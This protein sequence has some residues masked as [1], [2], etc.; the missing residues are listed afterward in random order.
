MRSTKVIHVVNCHAEGEVGDVIVG[1]V[2]PPPG[3]TLWEQSRFIASDQTLRNFVLNEPRG[4]V[5]RHVNLLVPAKDPRAQMG[6][7]IME[8]EDTPPMSG[9]N[10]IC[11]A[12]VLLDSGILPMSEPVTKLV[13][14]APGG[15]VEVTAHCRN[16]KAERIT[17]RNL[18]SFADRLDAVIEVE[19]VGTLT[20]DT[21]FGGDSFV[22][23]D[24]RALGFSIAP[25]EARDIA[26]MGM[27]ITDAAN[28]QLGF[29]HPDPDRDWSHISFCQ[30]TAPV[31]YENG[32][33]TGANAVAIKPGKIDRSPTGT[34]CSARMAVLHA[35]G[36]MKVGDRFIGRSIMGSEFH[37]AIEAETMIGGKAA[38]VPTISG[39]A[40]ITGTQQLML[41][42]DDP[43]PAGYRLS[44]TWPKL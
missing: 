35:R 6:W 29:S 2:A 13:L 17:V 21:A 31:A 38:I 15:V 23:A 10:S 11:V 30:I 8:P 16:G 36:Q 1:G 37:C 40:W 28:E 42:P 27:R 4:G 41:D 24:G 26:V 33:A 20:V 9:S 39:R 32:V 12:T 43:W 34:G 5:F 18:P 22:I 3:E 25:D 19:G 44:D 7:I 14:E